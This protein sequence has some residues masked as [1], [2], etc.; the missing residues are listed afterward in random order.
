MAK[1]VMKYE[2]GK[3]TIVEKYIGDY[4]SGGA[5]ITSPYFEELETNFRRVMKELSPNKKDECKAK[6]EFEVS[7][8]PNWTR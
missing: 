6:L 1:I 4:E 2:N 8:L 3:T 5:L 7:G